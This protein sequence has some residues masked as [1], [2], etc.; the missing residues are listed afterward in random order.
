MIALGYKLL[1]NIEPPMNRQSFAAP[2]EQLNV[3]PSRR[4]TDL[5]F[6][7]YTTHESFIDQ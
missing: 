5:N 4:I 3:L 2:L 6:E 1:D 7:R